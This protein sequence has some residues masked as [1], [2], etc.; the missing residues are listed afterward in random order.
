MDFERAVRL[1]EV[2]RPGHSEAEEVTLL[3]LDPVLRRMLLYQKFRVWVIVVAAVAVGA[4]LAGRRIE[5][6]ADLYDE[7]EIF[8]PSD[9]ADRTEG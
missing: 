5:A 6:E 9:P 1:E 7:L 4:C 3:V 2:V 8:G